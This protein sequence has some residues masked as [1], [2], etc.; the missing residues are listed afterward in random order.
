VRVET[1]TKFWL[2][3]PN[4][5]AISNSTIS[6]RGKLPLK[7]CLSNL[8]A[9]SIISESQKANSASGSRKSASAFSQLS[10]HLITYGKQRHFDKSDSLDAP[11]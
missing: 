5:E 10:K 11:V 7:Q 6:T 2:E 3:G 4:L 8:L 9:H 1:W